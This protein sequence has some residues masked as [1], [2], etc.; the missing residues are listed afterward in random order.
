LRPSAAPAVTA[1]SS[2]KVRLDDG[3]YHI[4][5]EER[6]ESHAILDMPSTTGKAMVWIE[7]WLSMQ[8]AGTCHFARRTRMNASNN[9]H[10]DR[11]SPTEC[12][13][14]SCNANAASLS[15]VTFHGHVEWS[16]E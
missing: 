9:L 11:H 2:N 5:H 8:H 4:I 3:E 6:H 13:A 14:L 15:P 7:P 12:G 10:K 16:L 1:K